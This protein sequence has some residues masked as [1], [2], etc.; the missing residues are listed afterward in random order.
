MK[1][2]KRNISSKGEIRVGMELGLGLNKDKGAFWVRIKL[3]LRCK[4][5]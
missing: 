1:L 5:G 2:G 3:G 4:L